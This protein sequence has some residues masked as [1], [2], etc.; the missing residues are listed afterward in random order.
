ME[1]VYQNELASLQQKLNGNFSNA[2]ATSPIGAKV[3]ETIKEYINASTFDKEFEQA[4]CLM[5]GDKL[6]KP[7]ATNAIVRKTSTLGIYKIIFEN[8]IKIF[9]ESQLFANKKFAAGSVSKLDDDEFEVISFDEEENMEI[10]HL[11]KTEL[12]SYMNEHQLTF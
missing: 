2:V 6:L 9:D 5:G 12:I 1:H 11:N 7:A 8:G 10:D 4:I 3:P